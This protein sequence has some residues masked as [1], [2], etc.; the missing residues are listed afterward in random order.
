MAFPH[1]WEIDSL[2]REI[3]NL[4]DVVDSFKGRQDEIFK[5]YFSK[6]SLDYN[7]GK[8]KLLGSKY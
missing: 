3:K 1:F 4:L 8:E 6:I 2:A 7:I 5:K